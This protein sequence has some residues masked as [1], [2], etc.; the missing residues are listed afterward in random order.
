M[1]L[2]KTPPGWSTNLSTSLHATRNKT[3]AMSKFRY[4]L[5]SLFCICAVLVGC[6]ETRQTPLTENQSAM[7]PPITD[8]GYPVSTIIRRP[9]SKEKQTLV[10]L[11]RNIS[12]LEALINEAE[13]HA[14]NDARVRFDYQ[15]L[16]TDLYAILFGI[17]SHIM[18][19]DYSPSS[20]EPIAGE[21]GR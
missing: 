6:S 2:Q 4:I 16:R 7:E 19:P 21:Y 8:I 5:V 13:F 20:I 14:D 15:Q 18:I 1:L 17:R 12:E 10:R 3:V 11:A 9:N